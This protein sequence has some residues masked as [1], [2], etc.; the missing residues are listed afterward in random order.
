VKADKYYKERVEEPE[1]KKEAGRKITN[2]FQRF[3]KE[4]NQ[5]KTDQLQT[6]RMKARGMT[7]ETITNKK[8]IGKEIIKR[9]DDELI[10]K[11]TT[12]QKTKRQAEFNQSMERREK[13]IEEYEKK[14]VKQLEQEYRSQGKDIP[15]KSKEYKKKL[16][17]GLVE[18]PPAP[19]KF[20]MSD[21]DFWIDKC[22]EA[23][24]QDKSGNPRTRESFKPLQVKTLKRYYY[25]K[26]QDAG[27]LSDL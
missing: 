15:R 19:L 11:A 18:P 5:K 21:K 24:V 17:N 22:I 4:Q 3:K 25:D 14:S 27:E 10:E 16:I 7:D 20:D 2:A 8:K 6:A 13:Q 26:I 12:S 9:K 23:G 1:K